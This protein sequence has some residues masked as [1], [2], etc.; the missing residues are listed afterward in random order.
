MHAKRHASW[1]RTVDVVIA[2]STVA[3][4]TLNLLCKAAELLVDRSGDRAGQLIVCHW[5]LVASL[6]QSRA[7][8]AE[9]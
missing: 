6:V 7:H 5:P 3:L 4:V 9:T 2:G 8:T 1:G